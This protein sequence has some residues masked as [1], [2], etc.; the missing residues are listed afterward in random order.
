M[1]A[2]WRVCS[3]H[4]DLQDGPSH[5][6]SPLPSRGAAVSRPAVT[7]CVQSHTLP[8]GDPASPEGSS[9][10][11]P[12]GHGASDA[13]APAHQAVAAALREPS[14]WAPAARWSEEDCSPGQPAQRLPLRH[15]HGSWAHWQAQVHSRQKQAPF[16]SVPAH[17]DPQLCC[18]QPVPPFLVSAASPGRGRPATTD[19]QPTHTKPFLSPETRILLCQLETDSE[20]NL[21]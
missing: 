9:C 5:S 15:G 16:L 14:G 18:V 6:G 12:R 20:N 2:H 7:P 21:E 8:S 13:P 19:P 17:H 1:L 4:R 3:K 10:S 11:L